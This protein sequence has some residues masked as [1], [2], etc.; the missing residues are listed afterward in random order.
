MKIPH[1]N[2]L[3]FIVA[4]GLFTSGAQADEFSLGA[5]ALVSSDPY[6]GN[7][8]SNV[9]PVPIINYEGERF[10]FRSLMLGY[11]LW[12]DE[13]NQV[14]VNAFYSPQHFK[15]G[16]SDDN[17]MK[18]LDR[19]R[20]TLMAGMSF[21][22][23]EE[24]GTLRAELAGDTLNNSDG[25]IGDFAY[26][27]RFAPG[28]WNIIPAVG[29]NWA[30]ADQ[31]RYYY[32]ISGDESR[33]STLDSYRPGSS[34]SPYVE[35]TAR[36]QFDASWSAFAMGRYTRLASEIKD[37]PMVEDSYSTIFWTGVSYMF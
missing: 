33:R 27:Y 1:L 2:K 29:V 15:P 20:G 13:Q 17:R 6:L 16:D 37:S 22:H 35:L 24:W 31:N 4:A 34:W 30:S 21:I 32:G 9:Y 25:F 23:R 11:Y 5:S 19:R 10:F 12:K 18:K 28:S 7:S 36:Y 8:G 26:L 14:S 3:V